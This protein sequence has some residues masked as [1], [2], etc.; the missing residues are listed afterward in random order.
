MNKKEYK[1]LKTLIGKAIKEDG[2]DIEARYTPKRYA[3]PIENCPVNDEIKTE[4]RRAESN[5]KANLLLKKKLQSELAGSIGNRDMNFWIINSWG[6]IRAFLNTD[7]NQER[8]RGFIEG[9]EG[10]GHQC[11]FSAIASFSKVASFVRPEQYF[12]Y[13]SRVAYT[14]NWLMRKAK[15][16]EGYFPIPIGQNRLSKRCKL[17]KVIVEEHGEK[18]I[19]SKGSA[20]YEYCRLLRRLY[21]D[22]CCQDNEPYEPYKLEMLLFQ[23]APIEVLN[24]FTKEF[25]GT[26]YYCQNCNGNQKMKG[27]QDSVKEK[28]NK[29]RLANDERWVVTRLKEGEKVLDRTGHTKTG[30]KFTK[31]KRSL[32]DYVGEDT[33]KC[34]CEAISSDGFYTD[35][36]KAIF[37]TYLEPIEPK[38]HPYF[39]RPF[40]HSDIAEAMRLMEIIKDEL[41]KLYH[42]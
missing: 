15:V 35:G 16:K 21:D 32:F 2:I 40:R 18:S 1:Q 31:G 25:E 7:A 26:V 39:I 30:Y 23:M 11:D 37:N 13:D 12:V 27:N 22:I 8:L 4:I 33:R 38:K 5:Y 17:K 28:G 10:E 19:L 14:L 20:Y 41:K 3:V 36:E 9:L 24:D 34:F 6:G 42:L 29:A